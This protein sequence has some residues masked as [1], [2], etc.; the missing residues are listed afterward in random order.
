MTFT[1]YDEFLNAE[2]IVTVI[3]KNRDQ[4]TAIRRRR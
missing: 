4:G 3:V 1:V 2:V